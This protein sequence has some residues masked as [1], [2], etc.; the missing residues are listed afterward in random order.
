MG[1]LILTTIING[2][3]PHKSVQLVGPVKVV[4]S[5]D[6]QL[7]EVPVYPRRILT[8]SSAYDTVLLGLIETE[9]MAGISSLNKYEGYCLEWK[10]ARQVKTQFH[11]YSFEK[12]IAVKPD[13]VIA[14][15]YVAKD[16]VEALRA[17][18]IPTVVVQSGKTIPSV[19]NNVTTLADL[20]GASD[21]GRVYATKI[22]NELQWINNL[23][24][25]IPESERKSVLFVSSMDG[26]T[27]TNSLFDDMC[28]Y[29]GINNAPS[30]R[31]YPPRISFTDERVLDM[32]P[33]FLLI[34]AY[35][36]MDQGLVERFLYTPA[37]QNMKAMRENHV[38]PVKAA[39]LYTSNQHIGEAMIAIMQIVYPEYISDQMISTEF[40]LYT[41]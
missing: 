11:N 33:D 30:Y 9:R 21:K 26:Y 22:Q 3:G 7:V 17:M 1:L 10:K 24:N 13:L 29:M 6:N 19:I 35:Q 38:M 37:F 8:L 31:G 27:G 15:E 20:V 39:Y 4:N 23:V 28:R 5:A 34:P 14:P 41:N 18:G 40:T 12:I 2:C 36:T 16:T 25:Q 32:N